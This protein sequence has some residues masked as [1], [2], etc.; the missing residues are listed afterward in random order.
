VTVV[1]RPA[2]WNLQQVVVA[3]GGEMPSIHG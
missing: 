2:G 3:A 1:S